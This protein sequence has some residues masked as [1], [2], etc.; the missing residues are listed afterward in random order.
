MYEFEVGRLPIALVLDVPG[1]RDLLKLLIA[2][3]TT[4]KMAVP[5]PTPI[6]VLNPELGF[7]AVIMGSVGIASIIGNT[8]G[9]PTPTIRFLLRGGGGGGGGGIALTTA[10]PHSPQ[11]SESGGIGVLQ[12]GQR[13]PSNCV[14]L[15]SEPSL[16]TTI[17]VRS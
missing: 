7:E 9:S 8:S 6:K 14:R 3:A 15:M 17:S 13:E 12:F 1:G 2:T 16:S 10:W 4:I 11:N 5:M